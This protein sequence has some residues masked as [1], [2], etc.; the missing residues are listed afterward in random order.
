MFIDS[1]ILVNL[2]FHLILTF[3]VI[4]MVVIFCDLDH[5]N[6]S[7]NAL[8]HISWTLSHYQFYWKGINKNNNIC[9][10]WFIF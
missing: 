3:F 7:L 5:L 10:N 8:E 2:F 1:F 4:E 6:M 9:S